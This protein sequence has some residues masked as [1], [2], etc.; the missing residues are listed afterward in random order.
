M[1][2]GGIIP[3]LLEKFWFIQSELF[4]AERESV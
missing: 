1:G 3:Q 4:G 2:L